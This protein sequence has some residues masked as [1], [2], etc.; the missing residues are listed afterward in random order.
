V[1]VLKKRV[2]MKTLKTALM[3]MLMVVSLIGCAK[4]KAYVSPEI[5]VDDR[6]EDEVPP[7]E[8][9]TPQYATNTVA[10]DNVSTSTLRQFFFKNPPNNPTNIRVYVDV[11]NDGEGYAGELKIQ[12]D[13]NGITRQAVVRSQHPYSNISDA[14]LN[15]WFT[16]NGKNS[17]HGIY[18]DAY[19]A[20]VLVVDNQLSLGDG[21][22]SAILSGSVWFQNFGYTGASQGPQK[23][24]W[25]IQIGPYDCRT[26]L[27]GGVDAKYDR[28]VVDTYSSLYP[29]T[30]TLGGDATSGYG[31]NRPNYVKLGTF[32]GLLRSQAFNE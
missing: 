4:Q 2:Y 23:M 11:A 31:G 19:G 17:F 15:K 25:E 24:C 5:P 8:E 1:V 30:K 27:Q 16:W 32:S 13:D 12:F 9:E 22:G 14:S 21:S 26:F 29:T 18:Q 10:L 7:G 20:V 6:A 3:M 28:A